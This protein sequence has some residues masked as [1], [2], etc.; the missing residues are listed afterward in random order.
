MGEQRRLGVGGLGEAHVVGAQQPH[1]ALGALDVAA[2]PVEVVGGAARQRAG[3]DAGEGRRAGP[4]SMVTGST[5]AS[6]TTQT[7][8]AEPPRCM[9]IAVGSAVRP[10][11]AKPPGITC[12][13]AA[14]RARKT[15]RLIGRG[16]SRPSTKAGVVESVTASWPTSAAPSASSQASTLPRARRG[17][18]RRARWSRRSRTAGG[19]RRPG[20]SSCRS[21]L[22]RT[23]ARSAALPHHQ[24]AMLGRISGSPSS[25]WRCAAGR[26]AARASRARPSRAR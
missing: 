18:G 10:M 16:T 20:R 22:A 12:Q 9:A 19:W 8:A 6:L 11:R 23:C 15:R 7:S 26:R 5:G 13:P 4:G 1:R 25:A 21:V 17:T 2:E 24:V 14:V 3:L